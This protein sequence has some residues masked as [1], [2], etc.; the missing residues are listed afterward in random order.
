MKNINILLAALFISCS[1]YAAEFNHNGVLYDANS[2]TTIDATLPV[3]FSIYKSDGQ[4]LWQNEKFVEFIDG[5]YSVTLGENW[6]IDT[7]IFVNS[8]LYL[9][10][11]I[12][13]DG[14]MSPKLKLYT[15]PRSYHAEMSSSVIGIANLSELKVNDDIVIDQD[16]KWVGDIAGL[17]GETGAQ[18]E[19][20]PQGDSGSVGDTGPQGEAGV[21]GPKGDTGS[22]GEAGAQG[23]K[24]DTGAQGPKGDIGP[25]GLQGTT[26]SQG[27]AGTQGPKGDKGSQGEAGT[28]GPKG[29]KGSQGEAGAQG[30]KGDTGSQGEAG[31]QGP[32][33]D[34]G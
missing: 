13:N 4:L 11:N 30:P 32:K 14:E 31:T 20:G 29:D 2:E 21:Q 34:T 15:T 16:G 27:E 28:Q 24:G 3:M 23:P 7:S 10:I 12:D 19:I 5:N 22:Q 26:G 17:K 9:G 33:G 18:G 1:T 8:D 25:Q 6:P